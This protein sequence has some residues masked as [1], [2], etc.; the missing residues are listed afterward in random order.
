MSLMAARRTHSSRFACSQVTEP[1]TGR[2]LL[3]E[4]EPYDDKKVRC[5]KSSKGKKV[6][7]ATCYKK[8]CHKCASCATY[9]PTAACLCSI[10][11][12]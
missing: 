7:V 8:H 4:A 3:R 12:L 10:A 1:E 2:Q 9:L 6:C 11:M 5:H